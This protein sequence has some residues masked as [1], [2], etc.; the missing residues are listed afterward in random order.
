MTAGLRAL[1]LA[2]ALATIALATG[3]R[4]EPDATTRG[5]IEH[6]FAYLA[7]SECEFFRNGSWHDA[8][9]AARHIRRKYEVLAGRDRIT[10][11]ESFIEAAASKSSMS[12]RPYRVRCD[13]AAEVDS[14]Q[15]FLAELSR[16]R[17][18]MRSDEQGAP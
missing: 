3:A 5:E 8:D 2:G 10:T 13:G 4:A 7:A 6:L 17:S 15:W 1:L 16:L 9:G 11:T 12:G 14:A 18:A